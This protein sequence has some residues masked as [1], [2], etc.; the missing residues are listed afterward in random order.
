MGLDISEATLI[1]PEHSEL[2]DEMAGLLCSLREHKGMSM[3]I[4]HDAV[5]DVTIFGTLLVKAGLA[6]GMVSGAVHTTATPS[7]PRCN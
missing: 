7:G 1:H 2:R 4:A 6:D 5:T 3:D